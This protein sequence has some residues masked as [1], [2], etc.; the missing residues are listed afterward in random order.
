L[1]E[2]IGL[3]RK[4]LVRFQLDIFLT[5]VAFLFIAQFSKR[6]MDK[7]ENLVNLSKIVWI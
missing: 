6:N 2:S 7:G 4:I 3:S 1:T 5:M